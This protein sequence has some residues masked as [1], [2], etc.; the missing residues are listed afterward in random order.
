MK[1]KMYEELENALKMDVGSCEKTQAHKERVLT[2][3]RCTLAVRKRKK[4]IG[5][6]EFMFRQIPFMGRDLWMTQGAAAFAMFG[7]LYLTID[8]NLS[9]LS[10][11]HIPL[12]MGI[13]A[14][15]LV[16]SSVPLMLMPYRYQMS[17]VEMA[18]RFSLP[19]LL[20][21]KMLLLAVEYLAVFAG[22]TGLACGLTG[23]PAARVTL[24]FA[25]PL[26]AACTGCVQIIRHTGGWEEA[27]Q[28]VGVCEG[29]CVC[30]AAALLIL[31]RMKPMVYESMEVWMILVIFLLMFFI[32]SIRLWMKESAVIGGHNEA[33]NSA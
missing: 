15:M 19:R 12:M 13:L 30:L 16:M 5:F 6:F 28:R 33:G 7:I 1:R 17:E 18:S 4:R 9:F 32:L 8:G 26:L 31:N 20:A 10:V 11:R 21:A 3:V 24:Y 22:S 14:I 25:L 29:Y 27:A 23:L 2:A